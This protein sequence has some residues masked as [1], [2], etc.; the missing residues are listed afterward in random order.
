MHQVHVTEQTELV[1]RCR[2]ESHF[3]HLKL[4]RYWVVSCET[5]CAVG[6]FRCTH[7]TKQPVNREIRQRIGT[8]VF[9]DFIDG[10]VGSNQFAQGR[11]VDTKVTGRFDR[12]GSYANVNFRCSGPAQH[13]DY[14]SN[15]RASYDRVVYNK[16]TLAFDNSPHW[17]ELRLNT[18][19]SRALIGLNKRS[20]NVTVT[21]N[22]FGVRNLR[23]CGQAN[24]VR[25]R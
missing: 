13:L 16:Q 22:R 17:V 21:N 1:G 20:P 11:H 15:R 14:T 25:G 23:S 8:D 24:S 3:V 5:A 10:L 2:F 19:R 7:C 6:V 4:N 12:R 9:R 18:L